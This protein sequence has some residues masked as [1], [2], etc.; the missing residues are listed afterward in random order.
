MDV[1]IPLRPWRI[2]GETGVVWA[3][4]VARR[5]NRDTDSKGIQSREL[6]RCANGGG[7]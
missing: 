5:M 1:E 2:P 6:T 7:V 3:V 4:P